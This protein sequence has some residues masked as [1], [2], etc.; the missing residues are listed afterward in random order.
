V[1]REVR[2]L[3]DAYRRPDG[4]FLLTLGNGTTEDLPV[5]SLEAL[6]DESITYGKEPLT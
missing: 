1:R 6:F 3:F 4:R 2:F 5:E